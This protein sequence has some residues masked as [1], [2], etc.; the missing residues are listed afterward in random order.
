MNGYLLL[1]Y[2]VSLALLWGYALLLFRKS[3]VT[4]SRRQQTQ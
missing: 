3:R 1:G 2:A 4:R